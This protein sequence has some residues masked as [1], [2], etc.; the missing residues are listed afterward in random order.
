MKTQTNASAFILGIFIFIGLS[1]LG[2]LLG[3]AVVDF[4]QYDRSVTVKGLSEREQNADTVIWPIQFT[5][6][7]ND[8]ESLYGSIEQSTAN[9]QEF[10]VKNGITPAELTFSSPA[11]TDKSAQQYGNNARAEFRYTAVQ[12]VTV[13]SHNIE[14]VRSVMGKLSELGKR[15]IVFTGGNHQA[16]T[17]YIFSRLNEIKPE[18]IE[19]ATRKAREVAEKFASDSQSKLGKIKRAS[20]GQFSIRAR[21][22]NHP[23][24][25]K[26]R[27][28]STIEYYLSD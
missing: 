2:F 15:G 27:V 4:K 28:V 19:E 26:I 14:A 21:N 9:I 13:Y 1:S 10:L 12:T 22:N 7:G 5:A 18:M 16:R 25:K 11:I 17:E 20:Q 8:L 23:H 3:N 6:A 24:I